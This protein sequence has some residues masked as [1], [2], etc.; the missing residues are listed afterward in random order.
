MAWAM[1]FSS[2]VGITSI[3]IVLLGVDIIRGVRLGVS[4]FCLSSCMPRGVSCSVICWRI[5]AEFSPIP[6]V[7]VS[8]CI[9][10]AAMW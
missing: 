2:S 5:V 3:G 10:F 1:A 8:A 7:K 4:F 9:P 6:A